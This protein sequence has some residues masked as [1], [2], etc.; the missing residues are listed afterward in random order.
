M[1]RWL[2]ASGGDT[3]FVS[4]LT[5]GEITRGIVQRRRCDPEGAP[6]L[7]RRLSGL[8]EFFAERLLVIGD[9][10]AT[11]G[12]ISPDGRSCRSSTA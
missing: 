11:V 9:A 2:E 12:E 1:I 10:E 6:L 5:V 8:R 7:A 3:H 4:V